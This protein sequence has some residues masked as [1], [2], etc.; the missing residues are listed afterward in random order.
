MSDRGGGDESMGAMGVGEARRAGI[1]SK[2][3]CFHC[4]QHA[5]GMIFFLPLR[6]SMASSS[7]LLISC[8]IE[9]SPSLRGETPLQPR[10]PTPWQFGLGT[11]PH[12]WETR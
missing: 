2:P 8:P 9:Q 5:V 1:N 12:F 11:S 10:R 7:I 3:N 6:K 4:L